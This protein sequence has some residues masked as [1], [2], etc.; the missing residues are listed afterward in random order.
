MNYKLF[1]LCCLIGFITPI[2]SQ[3]NTIPFFNEST[4]VDGNLNDTVWKKATVFTG[5][6]NFFPNDEGLANNQT[7]VKMYHNCL[8]YTSP[9]PRDA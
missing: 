6:H 3:N 4:K 9:S 5:F 8:L 7:E 2:Y 1:L